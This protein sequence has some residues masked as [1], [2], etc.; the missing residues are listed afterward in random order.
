[1]LRDRF[2]RYLPVM[3]QAVPPRAGSLIP[4]ERLLD[5]LLSLDIMWGSEVDR[6]RATYDAALPPN[7]GEPS[8]DDVIA[9]GWLRVVWGRL[10]TTF[11]IDQRTR[12]VPPGTMTA[13][14]SLMRKRFEESYTLTEAARGSADLAAIV[15]AVERGELS[16]RALRS[17]DPEWVAA[18]LWDHAVTDSGVHPVELR[19]WVDRWR[20]LGSPTLVPHETWSEAAV[21]AFRETAIGVLESE[22]GLVGWEETR[23]GFVREIALRSGQPSASAERYVA[24]V[25]ATVV[26]RAEW[27]GEIRLEGLIAGAMSA[28]GDLAGLVGLVLS[29]VE[30]EEFSPAPHGLASRLIELALQRPEIFVVLLFRLRWRPVLLADL[31]LYPATSALACSVIAQWPGP[32]GAWDRDLRARDDQATK[33]MAFTDAVSVLGEFLEQGSIEAGE[34]ASLLIFLHKRPGRFSARR[35]RE[36]GRCSPFCKAS[37][38]GS[39]LKRIGRCSRR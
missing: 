7:G 21:N 22:Q 35:R 11:E 25:P 24:P 17:Q 10:A 38:R 27:L 31:L 9:A 18:R 37:Y 34:V 14:V 28:D 12:A 4:D 1:M 39:R 3:H 29:D 6:A 2:A 16:P 23:T 8:F 36:T 32:S 20:L 26:D 15:T 19:V 13:L 33:A 30:G 5:L